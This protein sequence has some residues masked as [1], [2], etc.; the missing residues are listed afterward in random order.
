MQKVEFWGNQS[1]PHLSSH[2]VKKKLFHLSRSS[3]ETQLSLRK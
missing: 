3:L 1:N 2:F